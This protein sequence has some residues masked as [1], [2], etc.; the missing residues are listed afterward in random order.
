MVLQNYQSFIEMTSN[1]ISIVA[2]GGG[3]KC[4]HKINLNTQW[5]VGALKSSKYRKGNKIKQFTQISSS[6]IF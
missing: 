3:F 5:G 4:P 6:Q 2:L 1:M